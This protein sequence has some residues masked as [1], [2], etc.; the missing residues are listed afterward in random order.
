MK[1]SMRMPFGRYKNLELDKIPE[2]YLFWVL[3][4]CD[5]SRRGHLK[6]AIQRVLGV[7][8]YRPNNASHKAESPRSDPKIDAALVDRWYRKMALEFHP[9]HRGTHEGM[10]AVNRG[11]ELLLEMLE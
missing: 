8:Q 6:E 2:D 5:L 4:N 7:W 3:D 10:K 9:D 1:I 11:R